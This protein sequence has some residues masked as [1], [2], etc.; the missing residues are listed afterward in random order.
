MKKLVVAVGAEMCEMHENDGRGGRPALHPF[1]AFSPLRVQLYYFR[2][3]QH[4]T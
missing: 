4:C 2:H 3:R 1:R